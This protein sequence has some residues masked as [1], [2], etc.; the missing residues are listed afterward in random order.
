[1]TG[2]AMDP[3]S[4]VR[5]RRLA[6]AALAI[7]YLHVV[8]GAIVRISGSGYGCGN[9]WPKCMGAWFPPLDRTDLVVEL[10][11]RY[12]AF[13]LTL[14][15]VGLALAAWARHRDAGVGGAGGVLRPAGLSAL[16]VLVA[17]VFG[18]VIVKL[19][20]QNRYVVVVHLSLAMA[21]LAALAVAAI[22][23]GAFGRAMADAGGGSGRTL[24]GARA[25]VAMTFVVLVMGA[26]TAN[27]PGASF[28]CLGFPLCR[29]GY[30]GAF[31]YQHIQLTHRVLAFA[32]FF[33]ALGLVV[34]VRR[35]D[36]SAQLARWA[37]ATFGTI[38]AQVLLAAVMV[39]LG[40]PLWARSAHE[41]IG[42]A[43]WLVVVVFVSLA[44]RAGGAGGA[45]VGAA[46][47]VRPLAGAA[48]ER[49]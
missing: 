10:S 29:N 38:L 4:F 17:V 22:R 36:E 3:A 13:A 18:A 33:H 44:A 11:H 9:H 27:L 19:D 31:P 46:M 40:L 28:S 5:L 49:A 25:L 12:L 16:L 1:M 24:G 47:P 41:A 8:F 7:G 14:A 23:A 42:T 45:P 35:R 48:G 2:A 43:T 30:G 21:I 15:I 37:W 20:L 26:L 39:E 6:L 32:V 34:G